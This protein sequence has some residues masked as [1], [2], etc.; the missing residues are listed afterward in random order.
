MPAPPGAEL[1][2]VV[3][4]QLL[5]ELA[6]VERRKSATVVY[7]LC[8]I[9]FAVITC[10]SV[11]PTLS[12]VRISEPVTSNLSSFFTVCPPDAVPGAGTA[13]AV[14]PVCSA[15]TPVPAGGVCA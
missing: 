9:S 15:A 4:P 11:W 14:L 5:A 7:P 3:W 12:D 2:I 13:A 8:W 10:T 6:E 1:F